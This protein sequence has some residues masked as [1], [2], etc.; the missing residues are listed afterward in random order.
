MLNDFNGRLTANIHC[1]LPLVLT[2]SNIKKVRMWDS[3]QGPVCR[4]GPVFPPVSPLCP[5]PGPGMRVSDKWIFYVSPSPAAAGH[6]TDGRFKQSSEQA[7][8]GH[9]Q[10]RPG[11]IVHHNVVGSEWRGRGRVVKME[12]KPQ[13]RPP[14]LTPFYRFNVKLLHVLNWDSLKD[15][16]P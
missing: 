15:S 16:P 5:D 2:I 7:D 11:S 1:P 8:N 12:W 10:H 9:I 6:W 14:P 13:T 4:C 3:R